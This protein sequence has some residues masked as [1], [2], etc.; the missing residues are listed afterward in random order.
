MAG[1]RP[2][3]YRQT[4]KNILAESTTKD[5]DAVAAIVIDGQSNLKLAL[6]APGIEALPKVG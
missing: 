5:D 6:I 2:G 1:A 4:A 3:R